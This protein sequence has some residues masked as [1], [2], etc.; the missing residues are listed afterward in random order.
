MNKL[1][2]HTFAAVLLIAGS[3]ANALG[4]AGDPLR[5]VTTIPDL[6]DIVREIGG[7]RVNVT[8]ICKGREN[9]HAVSAKPSHMVALS[10]AD[11][12]VEIGLSLETSFVPGLLENCGNSKVKPGGAGF[13]NVSEGWE[14][15]DVPKSLSRQAGDVHPQG[16]P[17]MNL[18]PRA[19][20][21]IADK[22]LL[23]LVANDPGSKSA[24]EARCVDYKRRLAEAKLRWVKQGAEWKGRKLVEYHQEFEYFAA[25]YQLEMVGKIESKP[26]IPPTPNHIAEL[27]S[28]MKQGGVGLIVCAPWASGP[29]VEQIVKQTGAKAIELPNMCGALPGTETWIQMMDVLHDR[30]AAGLGTDSKP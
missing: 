5:V 7:D 15:I 13:V 8:T 14:A 25:H 6:A 16:N 17:H 18:D 30:M 22:L 11:L 19:G 26:G 21:W 27:V 4:V 2:L 1:M 20:E 24:Y 12:F 23:A 10:R 29:Q 3:V 28:S 9:L